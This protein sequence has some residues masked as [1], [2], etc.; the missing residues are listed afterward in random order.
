[1][2]PEQGKKTDGKEHN[3]VNVDELEK[4]KPVRKRNMKKVR[5]IR[6]LITK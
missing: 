4:S 6:T 1:M 5:K 3:V 2:E